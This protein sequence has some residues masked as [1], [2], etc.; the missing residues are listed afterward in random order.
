MFEAPTAS[1]TS[2]S[3]NKT[4]TE[5]EKQQSATEGVMRTGELSAG[6]Q[7]QL[8][9]LQSQVVDVHSEIAKPKTDSVFAISAATAVPAL[10]LM[11]RFFS[12]LL[13]TPEQFSNLADDYSDCTQGATLVFRAQMPSQESGF[14][15]VGMPVKLK[16]DAYPFQDYG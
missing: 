10:R 5:L 6:G 13:K 2:P 4:T 12:C 14:V 7:R 11:A 8:K 9:E 16:F 15:R 1:T 3:D